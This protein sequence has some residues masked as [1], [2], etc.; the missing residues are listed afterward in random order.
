MTSSGTRLRMR[1]PWM[2]MVE[3]SALC[4][5]NS[6][7]STTAAFRGDLIVSARMH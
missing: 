7:S 1:L 6:S 4:S 2:A 3:R 5:S